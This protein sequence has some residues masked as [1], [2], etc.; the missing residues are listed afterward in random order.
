MTPEEQRIY[1]EA[2]AFARK[3][4]KARCA[5]LADPAIYPPD[6]NENPVSVFMAG[7][8]GAG[9]TESAKALVAE[10]EAAS[11]GSRLL[12]IDA[13]EFR[14]EFPGYDCCISPLTQKGSCI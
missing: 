5:A 11:P 6:H 12:R 4:K 14:K 9:K 2:M 7:S 8:A 3:H 13:D 10:F 1:D